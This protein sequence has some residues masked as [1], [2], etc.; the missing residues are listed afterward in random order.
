MLYRITSDVFPTP[1]SP[2]MTTFTDRV[3][4]AC[5][6]VLLLRRL[7]IILGGVITADLFSHSGSWSTLSLLFCRGSGNMRIS[8]KNDDDGD[9]V[10]QTTVGRDLAL[11]A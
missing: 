10:T 8:I 6:A 9:D 2:T 5:W 11:L 3:D 4:F 7:P 1:E